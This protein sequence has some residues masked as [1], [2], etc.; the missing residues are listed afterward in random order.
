MKS[1]VMPPPKLSP[2]YYAL[3]IVGIKDINGASLENE[4]VW[5]TGRKRGKTLKGTTDKTGR[6][7]TYLPKGDI[8]DL[9]FKY[10]KK[11]HSTEC[12][13]SK[14]TTDIKLNFSYLGTRELERRMKEEAERLQAEEKRLK[15]EKEKFEKRCAELGL[16]LEECHRREVEEYLRGEVDITDTVVYQVFRRNK[17]EDKLIVCDVTGSMSPYVA[18]VV[19][20]YHLNYLKEK[21]LQF[22]LFNDGDN[23][24]DEQKKIGDTGGIYYSKSKG[25]DS[26]HWFMGKVQALGSGG[27]GPENNMEALI[28]GTQMAAPFKQLVMIADNHAPI[29][30]LRLLE[31]FRIPVHIILCGADEGWILPDYLKV[32]WKT[33]GSVH[34]IEEDIISLA[35]LT[36]GQQVRVGK[37]LYRIMGGEFIEIKKNE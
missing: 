28:K 37:T 11:Y 6:L 33:K 19:L 22:V 1:A 17:W 9:N 4:T 27:D 32:A 15:E 24:P 5:I 36:E 35:R 31:S 23:K 18:Q 2:D 8:Y 29:K 7:I 25:I 10:N 20:W 34:T 26:L 30:D 13:Y 21:N 14:G 3:V 12:A 16:T